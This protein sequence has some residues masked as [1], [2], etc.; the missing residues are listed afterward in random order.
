MTAM[1]VGL[2]LCLVL[3]VAVM[4]LV[5]IPARRE[6]REILTARGER[7]VVKV[8]EGADGAASRTSGLISSAAPAKRSAAD[9]EPPNKHGVPAK[10]GVADKRRA[11]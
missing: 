10:H 9:S 11:S 2:L 8:R 4:A 1:I 3:S 5:A 7:V 6:G